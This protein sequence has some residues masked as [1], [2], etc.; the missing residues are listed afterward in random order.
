MFVYATVTGRTIISQLAAN[1][2]DVASF[3]FGYKK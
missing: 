2:F 1:R 3:T